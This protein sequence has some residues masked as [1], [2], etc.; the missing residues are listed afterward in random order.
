M[1]RTT[2]LISL[3][4]SVCLLLGIQSMFPASAGDSEGS[5]F[6]LAFPGNYTGAALKLFITSDAPQ[7]GTVSV[8]GVGDFSEN[9]T[10]TPGQIT[11]VALPP[12][13]EL[14]AN[15]AVTDQGVHVV[16]DGQVTVYGL[17]LAGFTSD[18]YLALPVDVL[19]TDH[20]VASYTSFSF[21]GAEMAVA[22]TQ[23]ATTVTVTP[24]VGAAGHAAGVPF[25]VTL[26]AGQTYL[27]RVDGTADDLTG[28]TVTS[29]K[30]V[31]VFSG[32]QCTNIP[33]GGY[34]ACDHIVEQ[35][36]PTTAW[37]NRFAT[38]PLAT[39]TSDTFR[40]LAGTDA[41]TVSV[42]GASVGVFNRGQY[43]ETQ[44]VDGAEITADKPI[45]VAQYSNSSSYDGVVGDPFMM[46]NVPVEQFLDS[47]TIATPGSQFARNY[48]NVVAPSGAVGSITLD[49][50]AVPASS[51]EAI[52]SSGY[53]GA[54]LAV[55]QGTHNLAGDTGFGLMV[56]G[57][58]NYDSYGYA[59]GMNVL[60]LVNCPENGLELLVGSPLEG[61][62]S[63]TI[64]ESVEPIATGVAPA[65]GDLVHQVN[66]DVVTQ[67]ESIIDGLEL[68]APPPGPAS[69]SPA[70]PS[71]V[72]K[73]K[74]LLPHLS[75]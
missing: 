25:N 26:D 42:N 63:Q 55:S 39:R 8:P 37:G 52:G 72:G 41:T 68:P 13:S 46:M 6:W 67:V 66:C 75:L 40:V 70:G 60:D 2:R 28:T 51:F 19:G 17:S 11:E 5:E 71:V 48:V 35:L 3:I 33:T 24:S 58:N 31:A 53:S 57:F 45:Y 64:H 23:D 43:F 21:N 49:G 69:A 34:F 4:V 62:A 22:G 73:A 16:A 38:V 12:G 7:S 54:Q 27:L 47:Y 32:A 61:V 14:F 44:L 65:L 18:A 50:V 1:R 20:I 74:G 29:D 9:F 59:G 56:Y 15:D 30:A 36:T 10:T